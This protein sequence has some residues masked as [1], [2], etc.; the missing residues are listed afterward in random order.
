MNNSDHSAIPYAER[1]WVMLPE[2]EIV[3]IDRAETADAS[4]FL[5]VNL[6]ANSGGTLALSGGTA[7]GTVGASKVVIHGVALTGAATITQPPVK[8]TYSYPCGPCINARFANDYY[9]VK[10]PGP[11]ARAIHVI[12]GIGASE[13]PADVGSLNDDNYDPAPKQNSAVIGA[14]VYRTQKQNYVVA[15]SAPRGASGASLS[16]GVPAQSA[17]RHV[18]FDAPEQSDGQSKVTSAVQGTRCVVTIT[19]GT[20][21]AGHPLMFTLSSAANG[22]TLAQDADVPSGEPPPGGGVAGNGGTSAAGGSGNANGGNTNGGAGG[23][24]AS[25]GS[26]GCDC[27]LGVSGNESEGA[28]A[29]ALGVAFLLR[30]RRAAQPQEP[31]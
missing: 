30:R 25:K 15:S 24:G 2:G 28:L 17:S 16:Y 11:Q 20:G 19:A 27:R 23:T 10:I 22:C 5:Y 3:T 12:D 6:H 13:S 18:V 21:F 14:A 1:D 26:H 4:H 29:F 9:Q 8:D 7:T 31:S